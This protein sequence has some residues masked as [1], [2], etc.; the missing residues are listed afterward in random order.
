MATRVRVGVCTKPGCPTLV[1][2]GGRCD[3]HRRQAD[4]ARG[5]STERG[6]GHR[7]QTRFRRGVL[8]RDRIC[9]LCKSAPATDA[10]HWPADRRT[11]ELRGEDPDDP[12]HGRGL[13]GPC[14]K[15]QTALLQP[16]G[17]NAQ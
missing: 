9:V 7:H 17:W 1:A 12:K 6:Y 4:R 16:G 13:C 5:S 11:L 15:Q 3:D 2:G 10:D 8:R 14:H